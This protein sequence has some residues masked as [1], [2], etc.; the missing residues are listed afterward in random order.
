[1]IRSCVV[2][3]IAALLTC[4]CASSRPLRY[5]MLSQAPADVPPNRS[6]STTIDAVQVTRVTLPRELDRR[7]IVQRIDANRLH[8]AEDDR[9]AAPLDDQIRRALAADLRERAGSGH[10]GQVSVQIDSF[11][12]DRSCGVE[13]RASWEWREAGSS[14][15]SERRRADIQIPSIAR[16]CPVSEVPLRMS[17]ALAQLADRMLGPATANGD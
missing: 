12:A 17:E 11:M 10:T 4:A 9:W 16:D 1:M 13:L 8:I 3:V 6:T 14:A 7:E 15:P 5:Y 2:A